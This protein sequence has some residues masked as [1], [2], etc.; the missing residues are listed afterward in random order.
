[1]KRLQ[2]VTVCQMAHANAFVGHVVFAVTV[3][4][5]VRGYTAKQCIK[6]EETY[7]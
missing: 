6:S 3:D 7:G 4:R 2:A 5:M 1:V